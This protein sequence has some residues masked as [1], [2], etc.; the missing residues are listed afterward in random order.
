MCGAT[1]ADH[2]VLEFKVY[3]IDAEMKESSD[4]GSVSQL[5]RR[6]GGRAVFTTRAR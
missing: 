5:D 1:K 6:D 4:A 2:T 3:D